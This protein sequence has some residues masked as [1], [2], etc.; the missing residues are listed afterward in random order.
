MRPLINVWH[1]LWKEIIDAKDIQ[2]EDLQTWQ[3][4]KHGT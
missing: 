2:K 1:R 3:L 4:I